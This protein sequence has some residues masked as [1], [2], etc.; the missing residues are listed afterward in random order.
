MPLTRRGRAVVGVAVGGFLFATLFGSR[1]LN[2]VVVP[3][4][5]ALVAGY[6][7]V[8]VRSDVSVT[9]DSPGDG[10]AGTTHDVTLRFADPGQSA[11]SRP[12]VGT[13]RETLGPGLSLA[14]EP[15]PEGRGPT[16]RPV[17]QEHGRAAGGPGR[18]VAADGGRTAADGGSSA[19]ARSGRTGRGTDGDGTTGGTRTGSRD[20]VHDPDEPDVVVFETAVGAEP[21][22]YEVDYDHRGERR[23]GPVV[24]TARDVLGLFER[25]IECPVTDRVLVFPRIY[26]LSQWGRRHL[27]K[28]EE[29][30]RSQERSEFE[31]LREYDPGDPLRDI[32]WKTTA[33]R[34]DLVVKEFA[35]EVEAETI[36]LAAG[37]SLAGTDAMAEATGSLAFE[38][39]E[40]G[41]PVEVYTPHGTVEVGPQRGGLLRLLRLLA[42]VDAGRIPETEAD[43]VVYGTAEGASITIGDREFSFAELTGE[44]AAQTSRPGGMEVPS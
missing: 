25:D 16:N 26:R 9:R 17:R 13:V 2:A 27:L 41:I 4:L 21:L 33:K 11:V 24:V 1:S 34:D 19:G 31:E 42:V 8:R 14:D 20:A 28:L 23:F 35:A 15:D 6:V 39:V 10:F 5:V 32:H 30:G 37:A 3:A 29:L 43:V 7:Q 40:D 12:F 38:L 22:A 18:A 44:H 36:R